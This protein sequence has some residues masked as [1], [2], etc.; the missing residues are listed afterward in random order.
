M[1]DASKYKTY[2]RI[3]A[4]HTI[5]ENWRGTRQQKAQRHQ[6]AESGAAVVVITRNLVQLNK[7]IHH[8]Q[9]Q[10]NTF[11]APYEQQINWAL[12]KIV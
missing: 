2:H 9:T 3:S 6:R 5:S 8:V 4:H 1:F 7:Q 11:E 12:S 10:L